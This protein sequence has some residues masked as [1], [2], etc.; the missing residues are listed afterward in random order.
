MVGEHVSILICLIS[1]IRKQGLPSEK[2]Q[3]NETKQLNYKT[4][5]SET[6]LYCTNIRNSGAQLIS[7][8]ERVKEPRWGSGPLLSI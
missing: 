8:G 7:K 1:F 3:N 6:F 4:T 2:E 5:R